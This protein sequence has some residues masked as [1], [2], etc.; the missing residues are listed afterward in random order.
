MVDYMVVLSLFLCVH[1]ALNVPP[2]GVINLLKVPSVAIHTFFRC[3][4][5]VF[6]MSDMIKFP[7]THSLMVL[8]LF[9]WVSFVKRIVLFIMKFRSP[10]VLAFVQS[11]DLCC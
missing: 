6:C 2:T 3:L 10:L 4:L 11:F 9:T 7:A 5:I 1:V 8:I